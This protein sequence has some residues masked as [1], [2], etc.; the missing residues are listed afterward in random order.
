MCFHSRQ[1]FLPMSMTE[2]NLINRFQRQ[3]LSFIHLK[4]VDKQTEQMTWEFEKEKSAT[5]ILMTSLCWWLKVGDNLLN[6]VARSNVKKSVTSIDV[7]GKSAYFNEFS[8]NREGCENND[9]A[10]IECVFVEHVFAQVRS[11][12][13]IYFYDGSSRNIKKIIRICSII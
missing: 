6:V 8:Y 5:V 3:Y 2:K 11:T 12:C 13:R 4:S 1:N 7:A 10:N 9:Q